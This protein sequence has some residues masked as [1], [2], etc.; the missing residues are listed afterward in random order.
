MKQ[1]VVAC[2]ALAACKAPSPAAQHIEVGAT[3]SARG[4]TSPAHGTSLAAPPRA[5]AKIRASFAGVCAFAGDRLA[6]ATSEDPILRSELQDVSDF[7][8]GQSHR[9]V[10]LRTGSVRC[11]GS[12]R[13]GELGAGLE[14]EVVDRWVDVPLTTK[15]S[16][17]AVADGLSCVLD[18]GGDVW[19]WGD[20]AEGQTGGPDHFVSALRGH[21]RPTRVPL[22]RPMRA[23]AV[24]RGRA[25]ANDET[26]IFCWGDRRPLEPVS[27]AAP[28]SHLMVAHDR[29]YVAMRSGEVR[30]VEAMST[31]PL[32]LLRGAISLAGDGGPTCGVTREGR[33]VCD[34]D[35]RSIDQDPKNG[36]LVQALAPIPSKSAVAFT[37]DL[38]FALATDGTV[39][40]TGTDR[41]MRALGTVA[42]GRD[43]P[44]PLGN[45]GRAPPP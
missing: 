14:V 22:P 29:L 38:V 3:P 6:C 8:A 28:P 33:V 39:Y 35:R 36:Y 44:V 18:V 20:N 19:C 13:S 34:G 9:C 37:R 25:C 16:R 17:V 2:V 40:V 10:V 27:V 23:L 15:A 4:G 26:G 43:E 42:Q 5:V 30:A 31:R 41:F 32:D 24:T 1:F 12:N 11:R 21:V 45:V 7:D